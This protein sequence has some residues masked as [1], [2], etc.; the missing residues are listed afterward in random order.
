LAV[1]AGALDRLDGA[2]TH[3]QSVKSGVIST[4]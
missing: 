3:R 1:G 4:G 2:A